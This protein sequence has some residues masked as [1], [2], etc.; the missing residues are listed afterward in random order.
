MNP[1][2]PTLG[3]IVF[4]RKPAG[5]GKRWWHR[6]R[7][8]DWYDHRLPSTIGTRIVK[9]AGVVARTVTLLPF[10]PHHPAPLGPGFLLSPDLSTAR[11]PRRICLQ[12]MARCSH[13]DRLVSPVRA[14]VAGGLELARQRRLQAVRARHRSPISL[15]PLAS[16]TRARASRQPSIAKGELLGDDELAHH[17]LVLVPEH[18]AVI[19]VRQARVDVADET[20]DGPDADVRRNVDGVLPAGELGR[21]RIVVDAQDLELNVMDVEVVGLCGCSRRPTSRCRRP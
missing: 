6:W 2:V 4:R 16:R 15:P 12:A 8:S 19:H 9:F 11:E 10:E 14:F 13:V 7:P 5:V 20:H 21:W 17:S 3:F 18:V 1:S